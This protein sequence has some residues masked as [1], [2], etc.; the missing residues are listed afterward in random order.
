MV[1]RIIRVSSDGSPTSPALTGA[2]KATSWDLFSLAFVCAA[3]L[4]APRFFCL[5]NNR[6]D[7]GVHRGAVASTDTRTP[8]QRATP[9][10]RDAVYTACSLQL[11]MPPTI[12]SC[13]LKMKVR[14]KRQF[15][16]TKQHDVMCQNCATLTNTANLL[17]GSH[18]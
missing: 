4:N 5:T 12:T 3:N 8:C 9:L 10:E 18:V 2:F 1:A 14:P 13:T 15:T 7:R 16:Y 11:Q 6:D 17:C